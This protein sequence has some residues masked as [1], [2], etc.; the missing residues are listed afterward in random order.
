VNISK[1][2]VAA[3]GFTVED[4]RGCKWVKSMKQDA[5]LRE[6]NFSALTQ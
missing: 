2:V 4:K 1:S 6:L 5:C 3:V